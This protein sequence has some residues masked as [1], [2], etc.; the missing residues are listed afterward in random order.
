MLRWLRKKNYVPDPALYPLGSCWEFVGYVKDHP[1]LTDDE[2]V[3][4]I[5]RT[6]GKK[7]VP[8]E[9]L[10]LVRCTRESLPK[11]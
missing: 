5:L 7:V 6:T 3:D 1:D 8:A 9:V 10:D 11:N 2:L 4:K